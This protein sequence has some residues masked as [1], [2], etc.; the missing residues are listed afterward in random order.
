MKV[1]SLSQSNSLP[2][3]LTRLTWEVVVE[4]RIRLQIMQNVC[5]LLLIGPSVHRISVR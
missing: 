5:S 2:V 3:L 4:H 1:V